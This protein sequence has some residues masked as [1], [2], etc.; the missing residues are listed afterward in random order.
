MDTATIK[1]NAMYRFMILAVVIFLTG[2][3]SSPWGNSS[4]GGANYSYEKTINA[5]TGDTVCR[6]TVNSARDVA[7]GN[8]RVGKDCQLTAGAEQTAGVVEGLAAGIAVM[9]NLIDK[10]PSPAE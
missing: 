8:I 9:N 1:G 10:I 4:S 2:C 7:G 6:V 3:A 5:T